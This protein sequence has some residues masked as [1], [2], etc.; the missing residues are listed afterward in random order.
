MLELE[1]ADKTLLRELRA[2]HP[3]LALIADEIQCGLGRTGNAVESLACELP[4][5]YLTF[6]KSLG[7]GLAKIS[8]LAVRKDLYYAEFSMLPSSTFAEDDMSSMIAKCSLEVIE[9]DNL[10]GR[11]AQLGQTLCLARPGKNEGRQRHRGEHPGDAH[12]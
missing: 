1:A 12:G 5:D 8:A 3:Q 9:R 6:A 4:A 11:S 2:R 10:A 7:G